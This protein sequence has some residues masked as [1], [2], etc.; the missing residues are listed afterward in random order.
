M[1]MSKFEAKLLALQKR[2]SV[3]Q[4]EQMVI[5]GSILTDALAAL[6]ALT[7]DIKDINK[8]IASL[9]QRLNKLE[10]IKK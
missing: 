10:L 8:A 7:K 3:Y 1:G 5:M 6:T 9:D 4:D 2:D